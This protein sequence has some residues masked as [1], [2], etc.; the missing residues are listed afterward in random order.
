MLKRTIS[1]LIITVLL[2]GI[3][4]NNI[5]AQFGYYNTYTEFKSMVTNDSFTASE[6]MCL[7]RDNDVIYEAKLDGKTS[8]ARL[9]S[10]NMNTKDVKILTNSDDNSESYDLGHANDLAVTHENNKTYIYV[11]TMNEGKTYPN[12]IVKL[13][14]NGDKFHPVNSYTV[15]DTNNKPMSISGITYSVETGKFIIKSGGKFF[16][17]NFKGENFESEASFTLSLSDVKIN[18]IK[19]DV[20]NYIGQGISYYEGNLYVPLSKRKNDNSNDVSNV[21]IIAVF[22]LII[23][24]DGE[25]KL[26]YNKLKASDNISFR[27]TSSKYST[28]EIEAVDFDKGTLYFNTNCSDGA[29][30]D[31]IAT[32][33][34]YNTYN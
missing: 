34:R 33:N 2:Y 22:P 6:G 7:D 23:N 13:E 21:S 12:K 24:K 18:G 25:T 19:T 4:T 14:V 27:I 28:F 5:S 20:S 1:I 10:I 11:A 16:I 32:F 3:V 8:K 30:A 26:A 17:G 9:Y 31:M 29:Q 15:N